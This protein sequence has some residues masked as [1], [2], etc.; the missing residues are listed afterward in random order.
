MA[1]GSSPPTTAP[2]KRCRSEGDSDDASYTRC[3]KHLL[4]EH[5]EKYGIPG[6]EHLTLIDACRIVTAN[7]GVGTAAYGKQW[8]FVC[9]ADR[10]AAAMEELRIEALQRSSQ[11]DGGTAPTSTVGAHAHEP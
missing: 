4:S 3:F 7:Y 5:M 2:R 1:S 8:A 10:V 6:T 11:N 9:H